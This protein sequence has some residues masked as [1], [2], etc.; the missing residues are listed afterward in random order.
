M[1]I[2][3]WMDGLVSRQAITR[4]LEAYKEA[5]ISG[6]QNFMIGGPLQTLI[7]DTTNS[8]GSDNWKSL[9]KFTLK[10]CDRLGLT[11]GT[12]NCPGWSSS[13]YPTVK[14]EDAMQRLVWNETLVRES[15]RISLT[16]SKPEAD[17]LTGY[18]RDIAVLALPAGRVRDTAQVIDLTPR[19][20]AKGHLNWKAP[21]KDNWVILRF[22]HTTTGKTNGATAPTGGV[23]LEIDKMSRAALDRYWATYPALLFDMARESGAQSFKRLE[24]DSYEAGPQTWT[25]DMPKEFQQR[26]GYSLIKWLPV[27]AGKTIVSRQASDRMKHD[28]AMTISDLF[29]DYY[30]GYMGELARRQGMELITECYGSPANI[31]EASQEG[32]N[33]LCAEFWTKPDTWGWKDLSRMASAAHTTGKNLL[34]CEAFTCYPGWAWRD[35]PAALK[36]LADRAFCMGVNAMMFHAGTNNPWVTVHPGITFGMWGTQ[37]TP[38][39]TWWQ[40]GAKPFISYLSRCQAMLQQGLHVADVCF[41]MDDKHMELPGGYAGDVCGMTSFMRRMSTS[42]HRLVMPDGTSYGL[43]VIPDRP[44][45]LSVVEKI[46]RL[47]YEGAS[48]VGSRPKDVPGLYHHDE[49]SIA[50]AVLAGRMWQGRKGIHTYGKG[51]VCEEMTVAEA[52]RALGIAPDLQTTTDDIIYTH[53]RTKDAPFYFVANQADSVRCVTLSLREDGLVP[54]LWFPDRGEILNTNAWKHEGGR[55]KVRLTLEPH[56]S[57]FVVLQD[58]NDP[59]LPLYKELA[60]RDSLVVS[61]PWNVRFEKEGIDTLMHRLSSWTESD[62]KFIKYYSGDAEYTTSVTLPPSFIHKGRSYRLDLGKV[63]NLAVVRVNGVVCDTLWKQPFVTDITRQ[64]RAGRNTISIRVTNLWINRLVGDEH[65]PD[66]VEWGDKL[67]YD[68]V[69]GRPYIGRYMKAIPDWLNSPSK[70]PS[71]DRR[72]LVNFNFFTSGTP[73]LPSGLLGPVEIRGY[74]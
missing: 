23:G 9:F 60:M 13:A 73:I 32:D 21:R 1:M 29:C 46:E 72:T 45:Q 37:F 15:R 28:W 43:L 48:V 18:Y 71:K 52:L 62:N 42:G 26:R 20:D 27:L 51:K 7:K 2:W 6:V 55:T 17:S 30:Y 68:Y 11:F 53:R 24:I 54:Q 16:L 35:D 69:P 14:A 65:E 49:D 38:E 47:V 74:E 39:Q 41:L 66:D 34:Y 59:S 19:V 44:L 50:L 12:H 57:V 67:Y 70:R 25:T 36:P 22:G 33:A 31:Y 5:G 10:E 3:Q 58:K 40:V 64:L 4:E 56:G 8:I 63:N 61:T